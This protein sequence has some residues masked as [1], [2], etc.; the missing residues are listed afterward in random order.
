LAPSLGLF[1]FQVGLLSQNSGRRV[2]DWMFW[3]SDRCFYI[4]SFQLRSEHWP[5]YILGGIVISL[6]AFVERCKNTRNEILKLIH[7]SI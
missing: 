7:Y 1:S 2:D 6:V 5:V 3:L 4:L